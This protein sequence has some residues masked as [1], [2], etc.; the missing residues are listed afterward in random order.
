MRE[1]RHQKRWTAAAAMLTCLLVLA[2]ATTIPVRADET[3]TPTPAASPTSAVEPTPTP[4]ATPDPAATPTPNA[5]PTPAP[6]PTADPTPAPIP[7]G[8]PAPPSIACDSGWVDA[9][10]TYVHVGGPV[11]VP[12][13]GFPANTPVTM[14]L[15]SVYD[16]GLPQIGA[17]MTNA[18]GATT[19]T[20]V[21]PVDAPSGEQTVTIKASDECWAEA[22]IVV[23]LSPIGITVDDKTVT[24]G[25]S[26]TVRA[27][28]FQPNYHVVITLDT[29]PTQGECWPHP[30][31]VLAVVGTSSIGS[32]V[33]S[34]E[35][36]RDIKVGRH[37][38]WVSGFF[39]DG[40]REDS[41]GVE[42]MVVGATGT[43]PPT[44]TAPSE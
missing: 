3:P 14:L 13:T 23:S 5:D 6:T 31:R 37:S 28:G 41:L 1:S 34:V 21:I 40:M 22:F 16:F 35:I 17:G 25:Q 42:I 18:H 10:E 11:R 24:Q 39:A 32:M 4:A 20:G 38:L 30:C 33:A 2:F 15:G 29:F 19:V 44:D 36:P 26:V 9:E 43:L 7:T 8:S 27:G 12:I